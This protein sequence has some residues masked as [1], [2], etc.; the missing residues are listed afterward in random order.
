MTGIF[1]RLTSEG[2][3]HQ[4]SGQ[5]RNGDFFLQ[6]HWVG[7]SVT[8]NFFET[9][10]ENISDLK[11]RVSYGSNG[12]QQALG[13]YDWIPSINRSGPYEGLYYVVG[14]RILEG[15]I[16]T[17]RA[18][19]DVHWESKTTFNIGMDIGLFQN[20]FYGSA[21][22][23]RAYSSGLLVRL[24]LSYATGVGV[25]FYGDDAFEWT[26]YGEMINRGLELSAGWKDNI[27]RFNYSVSANFPPS[28]MKW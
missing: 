20:K 22:W 25:S 17:D 10:R 28:E 18:N 12:D 14:G 6:H 7:E 13:A 24:P 11:F 1:C 15:A 2:T 3:V 5:I 8:N 16:Q 21:E 4:N 19:P 27:G 23:Y 26:N 9:L